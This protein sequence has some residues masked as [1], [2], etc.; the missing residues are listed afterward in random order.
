MI[1]YHLFRSKKF[2][3]RGITIGERDDGTYFIP[4]ASNDVDPE[5]NVFYSIEEIERV[6]DDELEMIRPKTELN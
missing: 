4:A 6:L 5:A 2:H 3:N 1:Q